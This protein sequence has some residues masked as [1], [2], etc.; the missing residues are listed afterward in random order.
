MGVDG[1]EI[2]VEC[3][4]W[5]RIPK[6]ELVGLPDAA[7]KEAKNRVRSASENSGFAFPPLDIMVNLAPADIKKEGSALD[8]A[9]IASI[10][11]CDGRI[12]RTVDFSDKCLIGELSLSGEVRAVSGVLP[13]P[14]LRRM[15]AVILYPI[16]IKVPATMVVR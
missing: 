12:S 15:A 4:A 1:Y 5:D 16:T 14:R 13:S 6:F 3:S 8:L 7:V 10:L 11:Q 2:A 9:I